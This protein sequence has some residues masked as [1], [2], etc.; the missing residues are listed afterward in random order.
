MIIFARVIIGVANSTIQTT[1]LAM[2]TQLLPESVSENVA[3]VEMAL[4]VGLIVGPLLGKLLIEQYGF[5][6][7]FL[8]VSGL[9]LVLF[10]TGAIF[11][12]GKRLTSKKMIAKED[13]LVKMG[14][15]R[16]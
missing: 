13:K 3:R 14:M 6:C 2:L 5:A 16:S 10:I 1:S 7:P 12:P 9:Y 8:L 15:E 4:A 11:L